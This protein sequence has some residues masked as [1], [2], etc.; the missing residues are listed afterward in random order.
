MTFTAN[1][2]EQNT[3]QA[4]ISSFEGKGGVTEHH[5]MLSVTDSSLPFDE[6]L[7]KLQTAYNKLTKEELRNAV[8]VFRRYF[9]SDAANQAEKLI[10]RECENPYCALSVVQQAPLNGTKIA[11]WAWLQTDMA[12][13][14]YNSGMF[15]ASHNGY[16]H[17]WNGG[18]NNKASTSEYQTRLL[19][20]DYVLQLTEQHCTL[21]DNCIRTWFFV[22]NVDVNYA[23]VVKA[24]KEVFIT[25][26]LTEKTHY[27]S[28]TGIEGRHADPNVLVQMDAYTV[29]GLQ[30]DQIQFLYA[31]THLNPTYEYG[32]TFERGTAV[33][34]GDR[35]HVFLSGTASID[36]K[37]EIVYPGDIFKQTERMFEN[38]S[39][40]LQEA[41]ASVGD[42]MQA[43]VYLRDPA[44]YEVVDRYIRTRYPDLPHLIVLAPVCR[45]GWL[46]ETECIAT[47]PADLPQFPCL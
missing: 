10:E 45:P 41:G 32:V 40:L 5:V 44:D 1:T 14:T 35:K 26:N 27:I 8:A 31:P 7:D 33:S 25:Q 42:I 30:P 46:I 29:D 38:I 24:R 16:R 17:L 19:L 11:L 47:I 3:I 9:L 34:Y 43:I 22:Q 21:A 6:Q 13:A 23:G 36:N 28:S 4:Q 37:G 20:S 39:V 18:A 15:E 2:Y 12:T